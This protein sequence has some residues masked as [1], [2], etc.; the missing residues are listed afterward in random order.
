MAHGVPDRRSNGCLWDCLCLNWVHALQDAQVSYIH[1]AVP[2]DQ[3]VFEVLGAPP[4]DAW[5][6]A[7]TRLCISLG[8]ADDLIAL[9][10]N[11]SQDPKALNSMAPSGA[12]ESFDFDPLGGAVVTAATSDLGI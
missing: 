12:D 10:K 4:C 7:E 1:A 9:T 3:P 6:V 8:R 11:L 2:L 5:R